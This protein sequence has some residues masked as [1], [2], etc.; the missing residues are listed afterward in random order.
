[1][2]RMLI[3]PRYPVMRRLLALW[4]LVSLLGYSSAWAVDMHESDG[5]R[6][7]MAV[8][9]PA[10]AGLYIDTT[11]DPAGDPTGDHAVDSCCSHCCHG[12][13]HLVAI[14]AAHGHDFSPRPDAKSGSDA[15]SFRSR[16]QSPDLRPPKA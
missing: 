4:L 8:S 13:S 10:D 12:M 9:S 11:T 1:M 2:K 16:S 3:A 7:E 15:V 14:S 6:H 5:D